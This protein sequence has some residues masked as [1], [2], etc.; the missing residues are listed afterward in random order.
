MTYKPS[1]GESFKYCM[2]NMG[3]YI[4]ACIDK[5]SSNYNKIGLE[6]DIKSYESFTEEEIEKYDDM[7]G[8]NS[9]AN[10]LQYLRQLYIMRKI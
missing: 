9:H 1:K 7:Y 6:G 4:Q 3:S 8:E 10:H 2:H 5:D